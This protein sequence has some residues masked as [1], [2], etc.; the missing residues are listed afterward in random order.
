MKPRGI[1]RAVPLTQQLGPSGTDSLVNK[2]AGEMAERWRAG[3]RPQ[4]EEFL[5]RYPELCGQPEAVVRLIYEEI[6]LRQEIGQ[7]TASMEVVQR[8]PQWREQLE[9]I[10]CHPS[11]RTPVAP[12]FP[13]VGETL[14]GFRMLTVLGHGIRGQ[15]YLATQPAL[16]DRP[17][18]L[19]ITTCDGGEHLSLARLQH[20][21]IVPLYTVHDFLDRNLRIL[22]MPYFGGATLSQI[23]ERLRGRRLDELTG[24]HLLQALDQAQQESMSGELA[25]SDSL[26]SK[27][28]QPSTRSGNPV[29]Q[30]LA[31]MTYTRAICWIGS[32]LADALE[33]AHERGLVHLD[34]KPSNVL[35]AADGQPML[36]DF[37]LA[38]EPLHPDGPAP[39]WLGGTPAYMSPEQKAAIAALRERRA[40][41]TPVDGRSDIY[42]LGVLLHEALGGSAA[43]FSSGTIG[44]QARDPFAT[45]SRP[46]VNMQ[47]PAGSESTPTLSSNSQITPGLADLIG[48]CLRP[49]PQDRYRRAGALATDLRRYLGD[50]PLVGVSNRSW[51]ERWRKWR[52]RRPHALALYGICLA[53]FAVVIMVAGGALIQIQHRYKGA[54]YDLDTGQEQMARGDWDKAQISLTHGLNLVAAIPFTDHLQRELS[55]QLQ[56]ARKKQQAWNFHQVADQIRLKAVADSV[57]PDDLRDL[58]ESCR[59]AWNSLPMLTTRLGDLD[60]E[61]RQRLRADSLELAVLRAGLGVRLAAKDEKRAAR[62]SALQILEEAE[63]T[64]GPSPVLCQEQQSHAE[65]L[66]L[67]KLARQAKSK[68]ARLPPATSWEHCALGR[69]H[70]QSGDLDGAAREFKQAIRLEPGALWPNY[71]YGVCAYRR[72]HPQEALPPFSVCIGAVS[73]KPKSVQ[74]QMLYDRALAFARTGAISQAIEDYDHALALDARMGQ[75]WLNRGVLHFQSKHHELAA[76]D[77]KA[78]LNHG[79]APAIVHYNLALVQNAQN[80]RE[81]AIA[82]ARRS[83]EYDP[84]HKEAQSLLQQLTGHP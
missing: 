62:E 12:E 49:Q 52:R 6:C 17:V 26:N 38:Q 64:F 68:A 67:V 50:L 81:A 9:D 57:G 20:T 59:A 35:L 56:L 47:G 28:E 32:C 45:L 15:V 53:F 18:V 48:K 76:A 42:S 27:G 61:E 58:E 1:S 8:F 79:V 63:A 51:A 60:V 69:S 75:A 19:K 46:S 30:I 14:G 43:D 21:H 10:L 74:A 33:Y 80:Q 73:Q 39:T 41:R 65:A 77:L 72:G 16:A 71:Y 82:S 29:R 78:A 22:C 23:L 55:E 66:G 5:S 34:L 25:K 37:H 44:K 24:Q 11:P 4:A 13:A 54:R 2:L 84:A 70:W 3:Q 83:L 7:E 31:Q 40:V 36:L